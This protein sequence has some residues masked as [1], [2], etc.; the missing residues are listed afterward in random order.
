M[1]RITPTRA[2]AVARAGAVRLAAMVQADGR[3]LY[4]YMLPDPTITDTAYSEVRHVGAV[5]A[6][7]DVEVSEPS[8]PDLSTAIDRA[9]AYMV[10]KIFRPFGGT[11]TLCVVDEG[12]IK[13]GGSALGVAASLSL[14]RRSGD[15]EHLER[16]VR[17]ARF[18]VLQRRA[19]GDFLHILIP[20][21]IAKP[22]PTRADLFTG[23]AMFALA[24]LSEATGDP[25]WRELAVDSMDQLAK[26]DFAVGTQA[27]WMLY[28]LEVLLR[29]RR[30]ERL[31]A[32]AARLVE[33]MLA[34]VSIRQSPESTPLA[35]QTEALIV[36][37]RILRSSLVEGGDPA[38]STMARI[39]QNLR[40]QLR[41]FDPSGAFIQS[42]ERPEVRIDYIMH[43]VIGFMGYASLRSPSQVK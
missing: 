1:E 18:I 14:Y 36:Y 38:V 20:G 4:R 23:Q 16:A 25:S 8:L 19:D 5:W 13:L 33:A 21:P 39:R 31:L 42:L 22:H 32:Y 12:F 2:M 24:L 34:D 26:R 17:L 7:I 30:D 10:A 37:V 3:F 28:A 40:R 11:D 29:L 9:A 27:Q 6:L 35:C 41:F 43:N 15:R